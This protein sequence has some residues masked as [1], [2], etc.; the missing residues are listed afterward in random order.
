MCSFWKFLD[1]N[2]VF[3]DKS[4]KIHGFY[5]LS[6][7]YSLAHVPRDAMVVPLTSPLESPRTCTISANY[8]VPKALVA[9]IQLCFACLT[10][11]DNSDTEI[12]DNGY[13][14]YSLT[15]VQYALMSFIN[16]VGILFNPSYPALY[17]V[18]SEVMDEAVER[19]SICDGVVGRLVSE[20]VEIAGIDTYKISGVFR[21]QQSPP[22]TVEVLPEG[23]EE[24]LTSA[25]H[26]YYIDHVRKRNT[27]TQPP[28]KLSL[29]YHDPIMTFTPNVKSDTEIFAQMG[30]LLRTW[31]QNPLQQSINHQ[32]TAAFFA[33]SQ[34]SYPLD[35]STTRDPDKPSLFIPICPSFQRTNH[36]SYH[37]HLSHLVPTP[38]GL[39]HFYGHA[40]NRILLLGEYALQLSSL[41]FGATAIAI[42]GALSRFRVGESTYVERV[43]FMTWLAVGLY[44]GSGTHNILMWVRKGHTWLL[45]G[46]L[47][48]F[49][50][51]ALGFY[52]VVVAM[53]RYG[54]CIRIS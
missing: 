37:V 11:F 16:L 9:M 52:E 27:W 48:W 38:D 5:K 1:T 53:N 51:A 26:V 45:M 34:Q 24:S 23:W 43:V 41:I 8:S 15:V 2:D 35:L 25:G 20:P 39:Y 46:W 18:G 42:I 50:P 3:V 19:G 54:T 4:K 7:G 36:S 28:L 30:T 40:A 17:L 32:K 31:Q 6:D 22:T 29:D 21:Q 10:L 44:A 13:G 47:V 49:L 14:A 33:S 12:A